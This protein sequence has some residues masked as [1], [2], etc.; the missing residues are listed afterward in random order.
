M[1]IKCIR[2]GARTRLALCPDCQVE[3]STITE[4]SKT[5][6]DFIPSPADIKHTSKQ[7]LAELKFLLTKG[8]LWLQSNYKTLWSYSTWNIRFSKND[9]IKILKD[10]ALTLLPFLIA[11]FI[12]SK[13][14]VA[15]APYVPFL[16]IDQL[17]AAIVAWLFNFTLGIGLH[18]D[19]GAGLSGLNLGGI[20]VDFRLVVSSLTA[21][22]VFLLARKSRQR[23]EKDELDINPQSEILGVGATLIG[24]SFILT[25]LSPK[26]IAGSVPLG[27]IQAGGSISV[28]QEFFSMLFGPMLIAAL[29]VGFGS[30]RYKRMHSPESNFSVVSTFLKSMVIF[31]GILVAYSSFSARSAADFII[32]LLLI[33]T[34][35]LWVLAWASG[36]PLG[37]SEYLPTE[38]IR[39]PGSAELSTFANLNPITLIVFLSLLT[40]IACVGTIAGL[41]MQPKDYNLAKNVRAT[42]AAVLSI[43]LI[44]LFLV[45]FTLAK[46][47]GGAELLKD[48]N[49]S[50]FGS[51]G[52]GL[53][54]P[55]P[56]LLAI[57]SALWFLAFLAGAR[58]LSPRFAA[59]IPDFLLKHSAKV[60][61]HLSAHYQDLCEQKSLSALNPLDKQTR[62]IKVGIVK[63]WTK[64]GALVAVALFLVTGPLNQKISDRLSSPESAIAGFFE[65]IEANDSSKALGYFDFT[66]YP[67]GPFAGT[68][69]DD[70]LKSYQAK[71]EFVSLELIPDESTE[72]VRY[73]KVQLR[74]DGSD[75]TVYISVYRNSEKKKLL[76][77]PQW[78]LADE[79]ISTYSYSTDS[80]ATRA[81]GSIEIPAKAEST[82]LF[83]GRVA[84]SNSDS[85]GST[86]Y[87]MDVSVY[88]GIRDISS[89]TTIEVGSEDKLR[90]LVLETLENC[91]N[92]TEDYSD[93]CPTVAYSV[94]QTKF[95]YPRDLVISNIERSSSG[96]EIKYYF[97]LG[98]TAGYEETSYF[99]GG[100]SKT[101]NKVFTEIRAFIN[102]SE[103]P[104][105][106][107]F[108]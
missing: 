80:G 73:Y 75:D 91:N 45:G 95:R 44:N 19:A 67:D 103:S 27:P 74:M 42:L 64:R 106:I 41:T 35:T 105:R 17:G 28:T 50:L 22:V 100:V 12:G 10:T 88:R 59:T 36:V 7:T 13:I 1:K 24:I 40:L 61:I 49:I 31:V 29:S 81:I 2:C 83:P 104:Q 37:S 94:K 20:G 72:N 16:P 93:Y 11:I 8:R 53:Y 51:K 76:L 98:F 58:Y 108:N 102:L 55:N 101:P 46:G 48:I 56:P 90:K 107:R 92:S 21:L 68:L 39:F 4:T 33:P 96:S 99:D 32:F 78:T 34:I 87:L 23:A 77:F 60:R 71:Y 97:N 47:S 3:G 69:S 79:L 62:L 70:A 14:L 57:V 18:V 63:K 38:L 85:F 84:I 26:G 82:Y 6:R 54:L 86:K 5:F 52:P 30:Y 43:S 9:S 15:V 66:E 65:G 25:M 89:T